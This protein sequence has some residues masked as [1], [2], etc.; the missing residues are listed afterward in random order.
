VVNPLHR[1]D[2][3]RDL[4]DG[5]LTAAT[6]S[7]PLQ[8]A[9]FDLIS[10]GAT[11]EHNVAYAHDLFK[12][13]NHRAA[14]DAFLLADVPFDQIAV[15]LNIPI[16]V[17]QT[18]RYLFMDTTVFRNRL[19]LISYA[20][21]YP[22]DTYAQELVR[23]AVTIGLEYLLW[24]FSKSSTEV[25]NRAVVR[26]TMIDSFFRGMAH[27]G[28]AI[29]SATAKESQKWWATAIRN[30]QILEQ[31]DPRTAKSAYDELRLALEQRDDTKTVEQAPV[32]VGD[33]LH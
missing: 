16:S 32:P 9:L 3:V 5:G 10:G 14:L 2:T 31:I 1:Y 6:L 18:Y 17:I 27:K 22:G 30:A 7:D 33:I 12:V 4:V 29:T 21:S 13:P 19:E 24:A 15:T 28:N 11:D 23:A 25:D 26:R 20:Q 8:S